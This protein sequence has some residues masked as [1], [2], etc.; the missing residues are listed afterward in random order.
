MPSMTSRRGSAPAPGRP[1][2]PT[3]SKAALRAA[4]EVLDEKGYGN[5][6]L[7]DVA[8]R[9]GT[10]RPAL[11]RRWPR[12]QNLALDALAQRLRE[13]DS[14]DTGCTI[15]DLNEAIGAFFATVEGLRPDTLPALLADCADDVG[16]HG[17]F[18]ATLLDPARSAVSRTVEVAVARGD[19]RKDL[20]VSLTLDWLAAW[21]YYRFMFSRAHTDASAIEVAV[22]TLLKGIAT[23]YPSLLA[24]SRELAR[25]TEVH[26]IHSHSE[27]L[28]GSVGQVALRRS[29]RPVEG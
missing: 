25:R 21:V 6:S 5:F 16:L 23:D 2:D 19:L 26:G 4:L 27:D 12:R 15:C 18:M 29:G 28:P 11:Y 9:A 13:V 17:Q 10:T 14:P 8:R 20:D 24:H 1:V 7:D 22:E 3:I